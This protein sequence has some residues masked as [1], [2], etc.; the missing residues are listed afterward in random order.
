MWYNV[1][2][3]LINI[4]AGIYRTVARAYNLM[5]SFTVDTFSLTSNANLAAKINSIIDSIYTLIAVFML[6]RITV[7]MIQ[8]LID[9][10]KISDK[11][12]GTGKLITRVIVSL[13]LVIAF[14]IIMDNVVNPLQDALLQEDSILY[15]L[16][17]VD[18]ANAASADCI[19]NINSATNAVNGGNASKIGVGELASGCSLDSSSFSAI[20]SKFDA[21]NLSGVKIYCNI[22]GEDES[23]ES[24][25]SYLDG[26][27]YIKYGEYSTN[28]QGKQR[29]MVLYL[30]TSQTEANQYSDALDQG[31]STSQINS[32]ISE[33]LSELLNS[34]GGKFAMDIAASFS[35]DPIKVTNTKFIAD[36]GGVQRLATLVNENTIDYDTF[37]SIICGIILVVIFLILCIEVVIRNLKLLVLQIL[38]PIAFISYMNPNDKVLENW[39]KKFIGCYLDLF[40]KILAIRMSIFFVSLISSTIGGGLEKILIYLGIFLFA[41]T[42]PNLI[43]DVL[44]IK[45]MGGTFKDS[46]NSLKT[47]AL[48]G[49]SMAGSAIGG[50]AALAGGSTLGQAAKVFGSGFS[51]KF[52]NVQ[53][54]YGTAKATTNQRKASGVSW[55]DAQKSEFPWH[56]STKDILDATKSA[57]D[58]YKSLDAALDGSVFASNKALGQLNNLWENGTIDEKIAHAAD[59]GVST[60]GNFKDTDGVYKKFDK[61]STEAKLNAMDSAWGDRKNTERARVLIESSNAVASGNATDFQKNIVTLAQKLDLSEKNVGVEVS[62]VSTA[63]KVTEDENKRGITAES[64]AF[65]A[66]KKA[67]EHNKSGYQK[68]S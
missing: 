11:S 51:G 44:G 55:K 45:N 21:L 37:I 15:K 49:T 67:K 54:A 18:D 27:Y 3:V 8:Y 61:L 2:A 52:G 39:F 65:A 31:Y 12:M 64:K 41:K 22:G 25:D 24:C 59:F 38:A 68:K 7:T 40:F 60:S 43:S 56:K 20:D 9:P 14:P 19:N 35:T 66:L 23:D 42:V 48:Y 30:T 36:P 13:A 1:G 26:N 17:S 16:F 34:D 29:K 53:K 32:G 57:S 10:D 28:F 4:V 47:A 46:M 58:N 50:V 6:F 62:G 63:Y 33:N 5:L